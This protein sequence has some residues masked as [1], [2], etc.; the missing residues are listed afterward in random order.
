VDVTTHLRARSLQ[1]GAFLALIGGVLVAAPAAAL[2]D[3][4]TVQITSLTSGDIP[5]GG[6]TTVGFKIT[7]RNVGVDPDTV[8]VVVSGNG[9]TCNNG[10]NFDTQVAPRGTSE[11]FKATLTA[12]EVADG[13]KDIAQIQITATIT[14][15]QGSASGDAKRSVIVRGE[16]KPKAVRQ[17]SGRV[18][19]QDGKAVSGATVGLQDSQNHQYRT[20]SN[21]DGGYSFTSSD[22]NPIAVGALAV[23]A[24][25]NGY[26]VVS[27][28]AQGVAGKSVTVPLTIKLKVAPTSASPTPS[29]SVS[30]TPTEEATEETEP[31]TEESAAVLDAAP[32]SGEEKDSGSMLY[33]ILGGLLVAAGIGAIVLVLMRRKSGDDPDD[34]E[35]AESPNG[36]VPPSPGRYGGADETRLAAPVGG[37]VNDATMIA[38]RSGAPSMADAPT[39]IHQAPP[40]DEFPD[41]YGAPV[42][43]NGGFNAPGGWGTAGAGAAAGAAGTYG[44][45]QPAGYGT[46]T[47]FGPPV[48]AQSGGYPEQDDNGYGGNAYGAYGAEQEQAYG[49]P[50]GYDQPAAGYGDQVAYDGPEQPQQ[51]YDEPTGMYRAEPN[52]GYPQEAGYGDQG[53]YAPAD[54]AYGQNGGYAGDD[55]GDADRGAYQAAGYQGGGY[56]AA[57]EPVAEQ[58]GYWGGGADNGDGYGTPAAGATYGGGQGGGQGGGTYG[59]G[60]GGG[61]Y[62]GAGGGYGAPAGGG[63]GGE[64]AGGPGNGYGGDQGGFDPRATYGRPEGYDQPAG[65][66]QQPPPPPQGGYGDQGGYGGEQ[67]GYYGGAEQQG[68][69]HG[70]QPRQQPPESARPAQRR[71]ADWLDE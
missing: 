13:E 7:N 31:A 30:T 23:G 15:E 66:A 29:T 53:G 17:V 16:D 70:G 45:A 32:K 5:A 41:P 35:G 68:G 24:V 69:R 61:T 38:P 48:P 33:I 18:K 14:N 2:A 59:G 40:V 37:R 21:G 56:G 50:D 12:G 49:E 64:P 39:M 65:R 11:E 27:V 26:E 43:P 51:R 9:L 42:P 57:E 4:P 1:A 20:T 47:Q 28:N 58:G 3:S 34:P 52:G 44:A 8:T 19:D 54:P 25:K 71:P 62:G 36:V 10:C 22:N 67:G 63:Y 46:A 55:Y 6:K 60:Q